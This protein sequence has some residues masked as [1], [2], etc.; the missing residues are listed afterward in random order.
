[1]TTLDEAKT[2]LA[3]LNIRLN[4]QARDVAYWRNYY[5]GKQPLKF[6]SAD[7]R[8]WFGERYEGF[9]DNWCASVVDATAERQGWAGF[10]PYG[11]KVA[12]LDLSRVMSINDADA[13]SSLAF[14][15]AQYGRRAFMS[16]WGNPDD[17][18]TPTVTFESP[19]QVV[20]EYAPGSRTKRRAS[21]KRW[22]ND[23][24][25]VDATLDTGDFLWK[26]TASGS[27]SSLILPPSLVGG[28]VP[29]QGKDDTWPITNP[30]GVVHDVEIENRTKLT[31][32]PTSAIE[33]VAP[34]QDAINLLWA[35]LFTASDF[36][37]LAQ[38]VILGAELPKI[39]V[40]V[41]G[42]KVG[43]K[44]VD[45]PEANF[46]RII[47]LDGP[48]AKIDQWDAANLETFTKV[49]EILV[50]HVCN[51]TRTPAYYMM[52]G[53]TFSNIG[54][55]GITALDAGLNEKIKSLKSVQSGSLREGARLICLAQGKDEKAAAMSAGSVMWTDHEIRSDSQLADS[56]T[57][58][59]SV[60]YPFAWLAKQRITD[61]DE[62][63]WVMSEHEKELSDPTMEKIARDLGGGVAA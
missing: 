35:H 12:D 33:M 42:V 31:G 44:V 20:V 51:Q 56:Q 22:T 46:K 45:L 57:K 30:M 28:W 21:L 39:P 1:M 48:N 18:S 55:D 40:I 43:E 49:I 27:G 38:K 10:V 34:K 37:A 8:Q 54:G 2:L 16:V 63:A 32:E 41:D 17:E 29:R 47:A 6:A 11:S 13:N 23:D 19:E 4:A 3:R 24:G 50:G 61:P 7:W 60:G 59:K 14:T 53:G 52:T 26:W 9:S 25:S 5:D 15:E 58:Y 36:A 62:L